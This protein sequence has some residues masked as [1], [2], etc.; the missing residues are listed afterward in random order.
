[1]L[2]LV[3]Y[4]G[5]RTEELGAGAAGEAAAWQIGASP[6]HGRLSAHG[7][8]VCA[9]VGLED[10]AGDVGVGRRQYDDLGDVVRGGDAPGG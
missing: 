1:V 9:A 8:Q 2:W 4:G 6:A 5:G 10:G 7:Y 3:L